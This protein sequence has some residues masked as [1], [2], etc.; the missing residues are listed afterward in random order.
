MHLLNELGPQLLQGDL[1][2]VLQHGFICEGAY[3]SLTVALF[4]ET[5]E[6]APDSI[7]LIDRLTESFLVLQCLLQVV[8]GRDRLRVL[9]YQLQ[10]EVTHDPQK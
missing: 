8:L 10:C 9:I 4:E 6:E 7:L 2:Q 5:L 1:C 3:H